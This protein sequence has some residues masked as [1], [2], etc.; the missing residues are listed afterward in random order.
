MQ[1][2]D[3]RDPSALVPERA[4]PP[5]LLTGAT[6]FL[7]GHF[8]LHRIEWPGA[9]YAIVRG[10]TERQARA[11]LYA[12]L[13]E[14]AASYQRPLPR[15][16][17]DERLH[18]LVG[19][20]TRPDCGLDTDA[21]AR[22]HA[23]A[24]REFWHC[25]A[26]LKFEDRHR[27]EIFEHNVEGTRNMLDLFRR[28]CGA[29]AGGAPAE[30]LHVS[31]AYTAGRAQ[32]EIEEARHSGDRGYNNAY[33]ESKHAAEILVADLCE[34]HGLSY[35]ILRPT[36]VMGPR[37]THRSGTTRFGVYGFA[38]EVHRLRETL[39]K[40]KHPLELVGAERATANL[41]P[42]DECV[43]DMLRL[44]SEGFGAQRYF[45]LSNPEGVNMG[46]LIATIDRKTGANRLAFVAERSGEAGPLQEL[47]DERTRFYAGYYAAEKRFLRSAPPQPQVDW[48]DVDRYLASF[49]Q[50]LEEEEAGGSGFRR[51]VVFARDGAALK[52]YTCG[53][54]RLPPLFL[55]NAYGMPAEFMWPLA[56][57]LQRDFHVVTW[58]CRW[59]PGAEDAFDPDDCG[60]LAH[61]QDL[62]DIQTSLGLPP[63]GVVGWSSGAQVSLRA[64]AAFPE[65]IRGAVL[66]NP[67]VSIPPSD[68]VRATRFETGIR[69]LFDRIAGSHRMAEKYCELIYGAAATDAGDSRMLSNIL[70]S[71]DPYLLYMTSLPFRT[72][73]SL[74]RYANMMR[75]LFAERPDAW[76]A[77]VAQPVLVYVGE[78]DVVTHPDLGQALCD[79]LRRG[80]LYSDPD[81]DHFAHYY[82]QRVAD[83]ARR[84]LVPERQN[85]A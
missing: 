58:E 36:I 26:S 30:F 69:T 46:R 23:A 76:T 14:C 53:S 77:D 79:G 2:P 81:G 43:Y 71:T 82:D 27:R 12:H 18:V 48:D 31:T 67:G 11:R 65:R 74:F 3:T 5:I 29:D 24:P 64:M 38:K 75:T 25:A 50:E 19:D 13:G 37:A 41:T 68:T 78:R 63:A 72:P 22:L 80:E 45:H 84:H 49:M 47:F 66:L 54:A 51:Q 40:L 33:E 56:Q 7:G 44:S 83:L 16:Q 85:A 61:A 4:V 20:I 1:R 34:A 60:S 73:Q 42:V 52:V 35:R 70:T 21:L 59:V 32:G 55:A 39:A 10:E 62:V 28:L 17:L 9:V 6:G 57:R 8:L 15:A